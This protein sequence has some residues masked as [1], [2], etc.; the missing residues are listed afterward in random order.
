MAPKRKLHLSPE[1]GSKKKRGRGARSRGDQ[2]AMGLEQTLYLSRGSRVMLKRNIW[3]TKGLVNGALGYVRDIVYAPGTTPEDSLPVA[4]MVEFDKYSGPTVGNNC[5]P[6]CSLTAQWTD[7]GRKHTRTQFPLSLAWALTIH[8]AQGITCEKAVINVG[9]REF[10][11]GLIYVG[12]SRVKSWS[13][14]AIE[15]TFPFSLLSAIKSKKATVQR[16][17]EEQRLKSLA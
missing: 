4:I 13:G 6:I 14:L 11:S 15:P 10:A 1:T 12:L 9:L 5:I 2:Q 8:K 3:T 16:L 17:K 7:R